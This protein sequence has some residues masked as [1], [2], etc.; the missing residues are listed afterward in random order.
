[1]L[2]CLTKKIIYAQIQNVNYESNTAVVVFTILSY[3]IT[4]TARLAAS[5]KQYLL[6]R[7]NWMIS[8]PFGD[9]CLT[10]FAS[11]ERY[12]T[13]ARPQSAIGSDESHSET[14]EENVFH[15]ERHF[16][17]LDWSRRSAPG[18]NAPFNSG[19]VQNLHRFM[20]RTGC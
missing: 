6:A 18:E 13:R 10:T 3:R 11:H 4:A 9:I 16:Y 17:G 7:R 15:L 20:E 1:L 2:P 12:P 14:Q 5:L 19:E 8:A